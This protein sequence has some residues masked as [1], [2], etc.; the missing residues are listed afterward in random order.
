MEKV[1]HKRVGRT[2]A[3]EKKIAENK[4][5]DKKRTSG[6]KRSTRIRR[7]TLDHETGKECKILKQWR[8]KSGIKKIRGT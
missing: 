3:G 5:E 4:V 8:T 2:E 6:P 7:Q 1:Q